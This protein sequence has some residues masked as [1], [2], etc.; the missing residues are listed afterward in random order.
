M[1]LYSILNQWLA[2][3]PFLQNKIAH[4]IIIFL[5]FFILSKLFV[6]ITEKI[7]VRI[8]KKTKTKVDDLILD[9]IRGPITTILVL[10]G[11]YLGSSYLI[12]HVKANFVI[13]SI[14]FSA[15]LVFFLIIIQRIS[16]ILIDHYGTKW[17][18]KTKSTIDDAILPLLKKILN[19]IFI[20]LIGLWILRIWNI[21]IT[22][23]LAG[24]GIA[25][26]AIGFAIKDSLGNVFGGISLLFDK[27]FQVGDMVEIESGVKGTVVDVGIR[28]T[29][30]KNF[31]NELM[32][33]PNGQLANSRITNYNQPNI[34]A[35]V[36][37]EFGVEYGSN[38]DNVKKVILS[39]IK[40]IKNV[41]KDPAPSVM[42][43][44]MADSALVF[45]TY[46]WVADIGERFSTKENATNLIYK[47]LN[48]AKIGI[49]F[50]TQT[51]YVKK[52]K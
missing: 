22:G 8:V 52:Q 25:G 32:I 18:K 12:S 27:A 47:A 19:V 17:A 29:R 51:V 13:S 42:F 26:L 33:V 20:I 38:P 9:A 49:P 45:K 16:K 6:F 46:F 21:D 30:I 40:S 14:L 28:S 36:V 2:P 5:G 4:A 23:V 48:K 39:T 15:I 7:I 37:V 1:D 35:R 3:I 34:Q 11:L 31:D 50:P 10:F 43:M 44:S 41:L 24:V